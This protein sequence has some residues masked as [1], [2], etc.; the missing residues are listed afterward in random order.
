M[1]YHFSPA[2]KSDN[3]YEILPD[4]I[5]GGG[6]IDVPISVRKQ[7]YAIFSILLKPQYQENVIV[8]KLEYDEAYGKYLNVRISNLERRKAKVSI[9]VVE[10]L[11]IEEHN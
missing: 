6:S 5:D 11:W 7:N 10:A 3:V 2:V 8:T 9:Q 4:E 1:L